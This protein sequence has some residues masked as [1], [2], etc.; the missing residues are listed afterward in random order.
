MWMKL[1]DRMLR[2]VIQVGDLALQ[3]PDGTTRR[4]GDGT[5]TP[6]TVR[7]MEPSLPR[8]LVMSPDLGAAEGYMDGTLKIDGDDLRGFMTLATANSMRVQQVSWHRAMRRLRYLKGRLKQWNP[9]GRARR[10][11][12]HHYDLSSELY[13]LFLDA[14]KQY[15]CAYFKSPDDSLERAQAQKKA[16]IAGKLMIE[17]GMRV[18]DIGCGWGGMGLT[19]ARDYGARVLGV[20]LS[21][22]QHR[23]AVRRARDAGLEDRVEFRLC[24]YRNVDETFD[25][26]VSVGMFEHVGAPHYREYFRH[27]REKLAPEGVALIHTIGR[28][29][30]PGTTSPFIGRYIFPGGYIPA[31][32]EMIGAVEHE[33]MVATD[34]EV[35]R[36]H[37]AETLKHW[38]ERFEANIDRA[39]VLYD[40]RFCRMWRYYLV[41]C[42]QTFRHN[43]QVVFQVQLARKLDAVP[44]TRDYLYQAP[45]PASE[46]APRRD[47]VAAE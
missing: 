9:T 28:T 38:F 32:S 15:S 25:R 34:V 33:E 44:I 5:G 31:M 24:D 10:N 46:A 7:L 37:Y 35:W 30:P 40:E 13:D 14:D 47:K 2:Q 1:L 21:E 27:V 26:V 36:L 39:R 43:R 29:T 42:E 4:Y 19:L 22:E 17:P 20:T 6:V 18:L 16:H 45:E 3:G 12:A 11:V 8:R 41:A 23:V